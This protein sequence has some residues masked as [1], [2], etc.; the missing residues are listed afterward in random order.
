M[1]TYNYKQ[2]AVILG[3]QL[4]LNKSEKLALESGFDIVSDDA[5]YNRRYFIKDGKKWI[6]NID[7]LKRQLKISSDDE[8]KNKG[9]DV[10][11]YYLNI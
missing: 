2:I 3:K 8:L 5:A 6:H 10:D 11:A 4:N 9:Y 1:S 7:A